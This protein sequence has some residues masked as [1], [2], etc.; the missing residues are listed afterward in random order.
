MK[1]FNLIFLGLIALVSVIFSG[2]W[3]ILYSAF[4]IPLFVTFVVII[5]YAT[6]CEF[7]RKFLGDEAYKVFCS[8]TSMIFF[9]FLFCLYPLTIVHT[10]LYL[11]LMIFLFLTKNI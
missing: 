3:Y 10:V 6:F 9:T 11:A 1:N 8:L 7:L 5:V 4:L 2:I